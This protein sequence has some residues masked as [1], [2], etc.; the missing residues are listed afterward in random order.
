MKFKLIVLFSILFLIPN[1]F[2]G[3]LKCRKKKDGHRARPIKF[4]L[5]KFRF[6]VL[7]LYSELVLKIRFLL[8]KAHFLLIERN[9]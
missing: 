7:G 4:L 3:T 2:A 5:R 8:I 9:K 1:A 6:E